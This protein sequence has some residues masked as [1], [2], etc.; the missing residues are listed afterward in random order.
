MTMTET[1]VHPSAV[2]DPKAELGTG[3]QIGPGCVIGPDVTIGDNTRLD[4]YVIVSGN[5]Q[6]GQSN[7]I[8]SFATLGSD[9]QDL[10]YKGEPTSLICG[11][12]NLIREYANLSL[13]TIQGGGV[14]EV[15]SHNLFMVHTH[16]AHDCKIGSHCIFANS[17]S[18]GGHIEVC[19]HV[20]MG[21]HVGAHQ[22]VRVGE[23]AMVGGMSALTQ[24]VPP[25]FTVQ[26]NHASPCGLNIVG[27]RRSGFDSRRIQC[28]KDMYKT[29][30]RSNLT[31]DEACQKISQQFEDEDDAKT[32][33]SFLSQSTRGIC[34][35]SIRSQ[36]RREG[37]MHA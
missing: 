1:R 3:V 4:S 29:L 32:L 8:Y 31:M 33:T 19:D 28:I 10:K 11:D 20:V 12:H 6:I 34:R 37:A 36:P 16:I 18:L 9:P 2:V 15:G 24:D 14:T 23:H 25:F 27:L 26:G 5:V 35:P 30:Y 22:F 13:G 21:G 7:H 17:V